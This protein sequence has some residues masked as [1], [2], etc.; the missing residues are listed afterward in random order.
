M[1]LLSELD[2]EDRNV[3]GTIATTFTFGGRFFESQILEALRDR[4]QARK[5]V[6]AID[7]T[8]YS[9][10]LES[11]TSGSE[12][13]TTGGY[14]KAAGQHYYLAPVES[15]SGIFHP[16]VV[17]QAGEKRANAFIGS[18]NLTQQGYTSNREIVTPVAA[19]AEKV[20]TEAAGVLCDCRTYFSKLL[21]H[22]CSAGWGQIATD[23]Y[24]TILSDSEWLTNGAPQA[25][26][27]TWLLHNLETP[28]LEQIQ[29]RINDQGDQITAVDIIAP[30]Y[31]TGLS[32]P[33]YF[34]KEG[35]NTTVYLQD[36][37][38]QIELSKLASWLESPSASAVQLDANRYIHGKVL[39]LRTEDG[40][41]CFSGSANASV[42]ALLL[43]AGSPTGAMGNH[44]VGLLRYTDDP[45]PF[46]YLL[47]CENLTVG[48]EINIQ[49][50]TP[51]VLSEFESQTDEV[52]DKTPPVVAA[53]TVAMYHR[54]HGG[55]RI[56]I[57]TTIDTDRFDLQREQLSL[58]VHQVNRDHHQ[59][60][61][62]YPGGRLRRTVDGGVSTE[63][64]QLQVQYSKVVS[65]TQMQRLLRGGCQVR[66]IAETKTGDQFISEE[67]W[68]E[69][70]TPSDDG[71]DEITARVGTD[72]V[73]QFLSEF[74][75]ND[76]LDQRESYLSS[77]NGIITGLRDT[78]VDVDVSA[79]QE[80]SGSGSRQDGIRIRKWDGA[81][82]SSNA[83]TTINT[84]YDHW[85]KDLTE[86]AQVRTDPDAAFD[87]VAARLQAINQ[88]NIKLL[89][90]KQ[91][92]V[93]QKSGLSIPSELP[94][95]V[96]NQLYTHRT[97]KTLDSRLGWFLTR[98]T[99]V[100]ATANNDD[101]LITSEIIYSWCREDI[102]PHIIV[103][104]L[105]A[106]YQ[107][108]S[109]TEEYDRYFGSSF[110]ELA[111]YC[112]EDGPTLA[113]WASTDSIDL[114]VA[115]V[116]EIINPM[117]EQLER[118]GGHKWLPY[119]FRDSGRLEDAVI[120]VLARILVEGD[121]VETYKTVDDRN[122]KLLNAAQT[123][124]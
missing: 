37:E 87:S 27:D 91:A 50:F 39:I 98:G 3:T 15:G 106:E 64:S 9:D 95:E 2:A 77:L 76:D 7:A 38:T 96:T 115:A 8:T 68:A 16:K 1:K 48:T 11:S 89:A 73:P 31:G 53:P 86:L 94:A 93:D 71:G 107:L 122:Q 62:L 40:S 69:T 117:L 104:A 74:F 32:I 30:F 111:L 63:G 45:S 17:Y 110:E 120:G 116:G 123:E 34:T 108:A 78:T 79:D 24:E 90:L 13:I 102:L 25:D 103:G 10:T 85:M 101:E 109:S 20:T 33:E 118:H 26:R 43:S 19:E 124:L 6:V 72:T 61:P 105:V 49:S 80:T 112:F 113:A 36:N 57:T 81:S 121:A 21:E 55:S 82:P 88:C 23:Q 56:S 41:Y 114:V 66:L 4:H 18:A 92:A 97:Q 65:S 52:A 83:S 44:E 42:S 67:R 35:I 54:P 22:N 29:N 51:G 59:T 70:S 60:V 84:F 47:D 14:P 12:N 58:E 46:D 99:N 5:T 28:L 100:A 75:L 119:E